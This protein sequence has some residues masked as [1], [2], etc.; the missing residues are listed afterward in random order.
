[1]TEMH[2]L[3]ATGV[4]CARNSNSQPCNGLALLSQIKVRWAPRK[5]YAD[6]AFTTTGLCWLSPHMSLA[7]QSRGPAGC[8]NCGRPYCAQ[9]IDEGVSASG[10]SVKLVPLA[11]AR[12]E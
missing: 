1:M 3:G 2:T 11:T 9:M 7:R 5:G 4:P 10:T 8:L 6:A 12:I